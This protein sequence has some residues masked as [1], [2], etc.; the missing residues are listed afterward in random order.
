[1]RKIYAFSLLLTV[2]CGPETGMTDSSTGM[3]STSE[4]PTTTAPTTGEPGTTST[5]APTSTDGTMTDATTGD[6]TTIDLTTG[7]TCL[8][9]TIGD[10]GDWPEELVL[11]CHLDELCAGETPL[12][13]D[14]LEKSGWTVD[15]IDRARCMATAMRDRTPGKLLYQ[16]TDP[17][18]GGETGDFFVIE[19]HGEQVSLR[20]EHEGLGFGYDYLERV[21]FLREPAFFTACAGGTATEVHEC[22]TQGFTD[23]CATQLECPR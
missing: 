9:H 4:E 6:A 16:Q 7:D 10:P 14:P 15:D 3:P 22:L 12:E 21:T 20:H 11:G 17:E 13:F 23:E 1:M 18:N 8:E 19:I 5:T 2:G